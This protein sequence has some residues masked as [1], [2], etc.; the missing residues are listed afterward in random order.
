MSNALKQGIR[1]LGFLAEAPRSAAEVARHLNVERTTAWRILKVLIEQGWVRQGTGPTPFSLDVTELY[2]LAGIG[3]EHQALP[4]LVTPA[5]T[6][7]RDR[8]GESA[9]LGVPSRSSMVY[10]VY[11]PSLNPVMVREAVGWVRPMH[12]SALGKAY[13]SGLAEAELEETI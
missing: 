11:V 7:I 4:G 8:L 3:H 1:T 13:L 9:V 2:R 10:L 6:R 5:L 12:A